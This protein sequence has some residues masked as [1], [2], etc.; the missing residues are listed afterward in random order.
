[1]FFL[2]LQRALPEDRGAPQ[3]PSR[4][5]QDPGS[6]SPAQGLGEMTTFRDKVS[7]GV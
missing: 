6:V 5:W 4:A 3:E 2:P 1:M 7:S